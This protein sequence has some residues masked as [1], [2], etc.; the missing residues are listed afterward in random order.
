MRIF[1]GIQPT[2][3]LHIGN[4]IGAI[5]QWI[6]LQEEHECIYCIVDLH[7][8]TAP[9]DPDELPQHIRNKAVEYLACGLDPEKAVIFIQSHVREHTELAWLLNTLV[10]I[11]ELNRMT[12][13]KDKSKRYKDV[14]AG[15][16]NYPIL[17]A[18]DILLYQTNLVP[19]GKDQEQH[20]ELTRT[21][22][23]KFNKAFGKT[24]EIPKVMFPK[25]GAKIMSLKNPKKKMSKSTPESCLFLLDDPK[26]IKKKIMGAVTDTGKKIKYDTKKK[27]GISNLLVIYSAF[28]GKTMK[29][30]EKQFS[31]KNY[32]DFKKS[33]IKVLIEK[34]EPIRRKY[35]ELSSRDVYVTET[36]KRGADRARVIASSTM[37]EVR[38]N[39]GLV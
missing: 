1:S 37:E 31:K 10:P 28:S 14:G 27:P 38:K 12:Q 39:M 11:G 29:E 4:Y 36:L 13:F 32:S 24:F 21:V 19:V 35:K 26:L 34:L 2:G 33:L 15:L 5:K 3:Q 7:A 30:L 9:Q 6:K 18:A 17:M 16:F 20:V 25:T 22:A 8:I 23:K